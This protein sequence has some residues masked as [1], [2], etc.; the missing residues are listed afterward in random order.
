MTLSHFQ[1]FFVTPP[2]SPKYAQAWAAGDR[3][4]RQGPLHPDSHERSG[5]AEE[6]PISGRYAGRE[7]DGGVAGG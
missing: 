5:S 4:T 2:S 6:Y 3:Y 7:S 1:A